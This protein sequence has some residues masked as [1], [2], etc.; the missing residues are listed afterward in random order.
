[1]VYSKQHKP[2]EAIAAH[3]QAVKLNNHEGAKRAIARI[4]AREAEKQ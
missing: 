4:Q 2:T 1:V 3:S